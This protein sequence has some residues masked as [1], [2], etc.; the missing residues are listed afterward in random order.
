[1]CALE[2]VS[3]QDLKFYYH[4]PWNCLFVSVPNHIIVLKSEKSKLSLFSASRWQETNTPLSCCY[5]VDAYFSETEP[6]S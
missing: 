3:K 4:V 1:M 6:H 2:G 5:I